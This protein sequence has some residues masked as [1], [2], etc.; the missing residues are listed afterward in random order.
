MQISVYI[1]Q[2][3]E[4]GKRITI[5]DSGI[6]LQPLKKEKTPLCC[7]QRGFLDRKLLKLFIRGWGIFIFT[8][9][10]VMINSPFLVEFER[11]FG[12]T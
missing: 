6:P 3:I 10:S 5:W 2:N 4:I 7:A 9:A 11:S 8:T 12:F 1:E